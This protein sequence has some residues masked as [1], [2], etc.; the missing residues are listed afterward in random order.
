MHQ[1]LWIAFDLSAA[2]AGRIFPLAHHWRKDDGEL[3]SICVCLKTSTQL[4]FPLFCYCFSLFACLGSM[5][6]PSEIVNSLMFLFQNFATQHFLVILE[7]ISQIFTELCFLLM[8]SKIL[9]YKCYKITFYYLSPVYLQ[10]IPSVICYCDF[11][12]ALV[13]KNQPANAGAIRDLGSIPGSG[14][15]SGGGHGN[16]LVFLPGESRTEEPGR[17]QSIGLHTESDTTVVTEHF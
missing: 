6:S 1:H 9:N 8:E 17:L 2:G 5:S 11:L 3:S 13:V 4:H 10:E 7:T 14:R 12:V 16:P 15:S